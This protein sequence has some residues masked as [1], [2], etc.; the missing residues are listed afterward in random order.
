VEFVE[1][2]DEQQGGLARARCTTT[3]G[4]RQSV[5]CGGFAMEFVL[6]RSGRLARV[7]EKEITQILFRNATKDREMF[8]GRC[9]VQDDT[10]TKEEDEAFMTHAT[11]EVAPVFKR[12]ITKMPTIVDELLATKKVSG[13]R[14]RSVLQS[15]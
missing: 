10:F 2:L 14:I 4:I 7:D 11:V 5:A 15:Y 8:H 3:P 13:S 1:L 6:L 9:P 12:H